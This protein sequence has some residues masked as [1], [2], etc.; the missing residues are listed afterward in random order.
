MLVNLRHLS[1][2]VIAELGL[3]SG[4]S[5]S[6]VPWYLE[7]FRTF[8]L[9][10][11]AIG[12]V[13]GVVITVRGL[14]VARRPSERVS[15]T[16]E[17]ESWRLNNLLVLGVIG[18]AITYVAL[19]YDAGGVRYLTAGIIFAT[20]LGATCLGRATQMLRSRRSRAIATVAGVV[21]LAGCLSCVGV[22]LG[23]STPANP[24]S[25]LAQFLRSHHL[26]RGVGDYWTSATTTIYSGG[27]VTVRQIVPDQ[28]GLL[29]PYLY[30][31]TT[32]WYHGT[33]QFLVYDAKIPPG[34]EIRTA[35]HYP[36]FPVAHTYTVGIFR[37]VVWKS[38][39]TI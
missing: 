5:Q 27:A 2:T 3:G 7:V 35:S 37:V 19:T 10:V 29:T 32:Q 13:S 11:V 4:A 18:D 23:Q 36:F 6:G 34:Q 26:R 8:S 17:D 22:T 33:F 16:E 24:Y 39:E 1:P 31:S 15:R 21:V 14:I 25:R 12:L 28:F 30:M 9:A 20:V 38:P